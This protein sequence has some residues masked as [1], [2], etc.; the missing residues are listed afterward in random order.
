MGR[1]DPPVDADECLRAAGLREAPEALDDFFTDGERRTPT[2]AQQIHAMLDGGRRRVYLKRV[3]RGHR[4]AMAKVH[5]TGHDVLP[6]QAELLR[7]CPIWDWPP[8]QQ[9]EFE[10]EADAF[11]DGCRFF[12]GR[13]TVEARDLPFQ[14]DSSMT[15]A[16]RYRVSFEA[17]ARRY[18]LDS[19]EH[20]CCLLVSEPHADAGAGSGAAHWIPDQYRVKYCVT[21]PGFRWP[22]RSGLRF[23]C[24]DVVRIAN[25][26]SDAPIEH[27]LALPL[28]GGVV[29]GRAETFINAYNVVT[30]FIPESGG[31]LVQVGGATNKSAPNV[32]R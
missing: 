13:F 17:A 5:E 2:A 8:A 6:W 27:A 1:A 31:K 26:L 16:R 12:N 23:V 21:S 18:T 9:K 20:A 29:H 24:P 10:R 4:R 19:V 11:A 30:L 32:S 7:Y 22:L 15:L 14:L 25:R 28:G 3:L